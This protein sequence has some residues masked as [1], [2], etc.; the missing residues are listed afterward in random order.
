[1]DDICSYTGS[2]NLYKC[3]LAE[4]GLI[5]DDADVTTKM[6]EDYWNPMW[7]A[8]YNEC[9][10]NTKTMT[11]CIENDTGEDDEG[12]KVNLYTSD[13]RKKMEQTATAL[14]NATAPRSK[15]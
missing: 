11:E 9:D 5:I 10:C 12:E 2:Q 4:W 3:D 15:S 1:M 13:G 14:I 6:M 7:K 8:S